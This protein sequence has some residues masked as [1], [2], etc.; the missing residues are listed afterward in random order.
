MR[1][2]L[3][4]LTLALCLGSVV[5]NAL[6]ATEVQIVGVKGDE[7]DAGVSLAIEELSAALQAN[8]QKAVVTYLDP[9]AALPTGDLICVGRPMQVAGKP[10]QPARPDGFRVEP[11]PEPGRRAVVVEGDLRG[12]M[13]GLMKLAERIRL[14]ADPWQTRI[15]SLPAFPLRIF[16]EEGQLLDM[17]DIA[18]RSE[19]PPYV[20][21]S[22]LRADVDDA[23]KLLRHVAAQGYNAFAV[24]H[25]N[26]EEYIDYRYLDKEIYA[27][28][29]RHRARSPVFCKYLGELCR[30]AHRLHLG[31]YVQVYEFVYPP[32]LKELYD[33]RLQ[34]RDLQ[35]VL[36]AR[37]KEFFERV[38]L[39][40]MIVTATEQYPRCGY[41][42]CQLW[43]TRAEAARMATL[44]HKACALA[45]GKSIFRLWGIAKVAATFKEVADAVPNDVVFEMKNTGCDFYLNQ[46]LNNALTSDLPRKQPVVVNFDAFGQYG[47]WSRLFA[48]MKRW[49]EHVRT[50]HQ[51]GAVG[52]NVWGCWA[53]GC[54][55]ADTDNYSWLGHWNS[56]RMFLRGFT[57]GQA[58]TYLLSRLM[59]NPNEDVTQ[60]TRDF[61]AL[62]LGRANAAAAAEALLATEDAFVE[63]YVRGAAACYI[64]WT[65]IY[66]PRAPEMEK[67]YA[68]NSLDDILASNARALSHVERMERA[69]ARVDPT[70]TPD[71]NRYLAF[72]EGIDKTALY[73]R[74]FC[75]W[76]EGWWR[77]RAARDLQDEAKTANDMALS[78]VKARLKAI[79]NQWQR[80]P[81]E[82]GHWCITFRYGKPTLA[83]ASVW[84]QS[85]SMEEAAQAFATTGTEP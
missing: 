12:K 43:K 22:R 72:R 61:C 54:I 5:G 59:W 85:Q 25:L 71:A 82:A 80:Y 6:A 37:Y 31:F 8:S 24:L 57:P 79:F 1:V 19:Q 2:R 9:A 60:I 51:N 34:S 42:A 55:N 64:K 33:L 7:H 45:G 75:T 44:F 32:R 50:S 30:E 14:G 84:G 63:E 49:G 20:N 11:V 78:Q 15:E 41:Q 29:D 23:K 65:M 16:S 53:P 48:Y 66:V 10:W 69:F 46:P 26:I 21:E 70:K 81:E 28:D 77:W 18:Y 4:C 68:T 27:K 76:R 47:G 36:N 39:D 58:N 67:A 38:P 74:T 17:P 73:L 3:H 13:Y 62:H 40:G 83:R 35:R 52:I 56:F